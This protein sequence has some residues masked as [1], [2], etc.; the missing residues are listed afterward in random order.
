MT[1]SKIIHASQKLS[2]EELQK[3]QAYLQNQIASKEKGP[4]IDRK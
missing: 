4:D 2:L 1:L 3:L